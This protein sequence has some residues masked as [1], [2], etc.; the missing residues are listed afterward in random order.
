MEQTTVYWNAI[1]DNSIVEPKINDHINKVLVD[2]TYSD[3]EILYK[4]NNSLELGRRI[5]I[6]KYFENGNDKDLKFSETVVKHLEDDLGSI[7]F[8]ERW[9]NLNKYYSDL[10]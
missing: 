6:I 3:F 10:L 7:D 2:I 5:Y 9:T 8:D 1:S 4:A